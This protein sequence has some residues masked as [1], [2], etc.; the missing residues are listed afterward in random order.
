VYA[1]VLEVEMVLFNKMNQKPGS[2]PLIGLLFSNIDSNYSRSKH[3]SLFYIGFG[4]ILSQ[5]LLVREFLVSFYGNELSIGIIFACWLVW[6]GLGSAFGNV[7]VKHNRNVS[8]L[9]PVIIAVTPFVT[10]AQILAV[11]FVRAFLH[12]TTG[13]FLSML[14]LL[15]FSFVVLSVGCLLWGLLFTLGAKS[16]V[17]EKDE[18]WFGVNK[19]YVLES[20][21]SVAGGLLFSFVFVTWFSALQIVFLLIILAIGVAL[22]IV[23]SAKKL[24]T[25]LFIAGLAILFAV[26]LQPIHV[27]EYKIN[28]CQWSF[29][30][31]KLKFVRSIDT[32]YQNL[33]LL[34]LEN[35]YTVY[36]DGRPA[37]NI[38]NTYDAELFTHSIM[39]H[40]TDAKR[41]LVLGA[42]FNGVL[43]EVLKYPVQEVEYVEIDPA[44]LPFVEPV[45]NI[46]DQQA[47]HD[48][49]V[50]TVFMDGRDF[51]RHKMPSFDVILMNVGEP[52]TASLNR[53]YT[54]EFF[55]QCRQSLNSNG[56]F[57]F[58]FPSSDEYIADELRDLNA[59]LYQTFKHVFDNTL[60]IPGTHAILIGTT[61]VQPLISQPD[62]LAHRYAVAGISAEYFTKYMF[63]ELMPQDQIKFITNTLETAKDI[64][65]NID[66]NP[67]TYYYDLLLW[68]KFL[69]GSNLFFSFI[70]SFWIFVV[71][72]V[73]SGLALLFILLRQRQPEKQRQ[74]ALAVI[75]AICGMIGMALNL[76]FLLNFQEA[77]GSIYEMVGAMIAANMLGLALGT[78]V[79]SRLIRYYKQ[80][81]LLL[82][83]LI[84]LVSL[85]LLLPKLLNIL[86]FVQRIPATL[87]VT[88]LSGG[89]IGMLFGLVN[90]FYL[91]NSSNVGS[92]YAFDVFGSSIGAL[93]TCSVLLPVLG[94]Q[95]VVYFLSLL[96][97]PA[98]LATLVL[99]KQAIL[100]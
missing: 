90:R 32:K 76:L 96:L 99:R 30:N 61:S 81:T 6:I 34:Y 18:L 37:Y 60:I 98:V 58:S 27:L 22:W 16:M 89:L 87:L 45:A 20:L 70:T 92:V 49:R 42:G 64:R 8:R 57:A 50:H 11:K 91:N 69:Q 1:G 41:V 19:A 36:A 10:F 54:I 44:L 25:T 71:G 94:I 55:K 51:L 66:S 33:S 12:T 38:P 52:S 35:Q 17:S 86:L 46:Q 40:R 68:N 85:V 7:V 47:L 97:V 75:I 78:L 95:G 43:K 21:G 77:F 67:V 100:K 9:F 72:A 88:L 80:K 2:K 14:D 73:I 53:F 24:L 29:I 63:G 59:S 56:V 15:G 31:D 26:L 65:I 82:A 4:S 79:A 39:I 3:V 93:T 74:T 84:A 13:E 5:I 23:P 83:V 48:F 62:S 28:T